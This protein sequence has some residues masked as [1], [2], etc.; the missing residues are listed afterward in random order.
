[1]DPRAPADLA[2][3]REAEGL[4]AAA[5]NTDFAAR[6]LLAIA[7]ELAADDKHRDAV[8]VLQDARAIVPHDAVVHERLLESAVG[9][10][11]FEP[12][13]R[14]LSTAADCLTLADRLTAAGWSDG[15]VMALDEAVRLSPESAD[16]RARAA[17]VRRE[18][19]DHTGALDHLSAIREVDD[20]DLQT[21]A[22]DSALRT[23]RREEALQRLRTLL[24]Q[25]RIS[26]QDMG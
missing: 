21:M 6:E 12:L 9:A 26:D 14:S 2:A 3:G 15:A 16:V 23:G 19:G 25:G 8:D 24:D 18:R 7:A 22:L 11:L 4:A 5:G 1:G 20:P 13:K 17:R 10:K